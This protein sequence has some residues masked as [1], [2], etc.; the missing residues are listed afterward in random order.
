MY[1]KID[2]FYQDWHHEGESTAKVLKNLTDGSLRHTVMEGSRSIGFI[3]W[4]LAIS[5]GVFAQNTG[6]KVELLQ[7]DSPPS[8]AQEIVDAYQRATQ[9]FEDEV[10]KKWTDDS[11]VETINMFGQ[12]M[13][14]G[15]LLSF[16]ILH[17]AHHRGQLTVLMRQAGLRVPGVYGPAKE[18]WEAMGIPAMK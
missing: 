18:E 9:S 15:K 14:K 5:S 2:D 13:T 17:Q 12:E 7:Q 11:L 4:H 16:M 1:R 6:L 10:L 3:A 8:S